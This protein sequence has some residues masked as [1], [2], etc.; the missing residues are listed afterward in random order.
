MAENIIVIGGGIVGVCNALALQQSGHQVT[1]VERGL[2]GRET[3]YGNAGVLCDGAVLVLNNPDLW[4][5]LPA[6]LLGKGNGLRYSPWFVVRR[7]GWFA[8]FLVRATDR[9]ARQAAVA[10]RDLQ[11]ASLAQHKAWIKEAGAD[12]LLHHA[13]WLK[14]F[15]SED[16][17]QSYR[18]ELEVMDSVGVQTTIYERAQLRQLEPGLKSV[19][20]KGVL[21]DGTCRVT[22]PLALTDAY[23]ALFRAAGGEIV[24]GDVRELTPAQS[25][26]DSW[27]INLVDGTA[28]SA[29]HVVLAAGPWSAQIAATLGYDIPMAWERGYH[30]HLA[31]GDGPQLTRAVHDIDGGFVMAPMQQGIR[32]TSGVEITDIDAPKNFSQINRSV[33]LARTAHDMQAPIEDEPWMGRRPTVIDSLPMIGP[34][35]RHTGLWFNFG[36]Q[37]VGLSMG[38]GSGLA[39]AAMINATTLGFDASPFRADRFPI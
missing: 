2:P 8:K 21:F 31:P 11:L 9:R 7:L 24:Q 23:L 18:Y 15:R 29:A 5:S 36:H 38:P 10:L 1:I 4:K 28:L 34:A 39:V 35:P 22:N 17:F 19:Y 37:H 27:Q 12:D 14:V 20:E 25:Q 6:L 30:T 26:R 32:I 13:A 16:S 3:S 33:E